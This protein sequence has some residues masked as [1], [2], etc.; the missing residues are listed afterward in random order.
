M[1]TQHPLS[2]SVAALTLI[3]RI[4]SISTHCYTNLYDS[5]EKIN[6]LSLNFKYSVYRM[7]VIRTLYFTRC[8]YTLFVPLP[9]RYNRSDPNT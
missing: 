8:S 7:R 5:Y 3:A 6:L 2:K 4:L 9:N 1:Y